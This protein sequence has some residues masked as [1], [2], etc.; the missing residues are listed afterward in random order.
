MY[1]LREGIFKLFIAFSILNAT[2]PAPPLIPEVQAIKNHEKITLMWDSKAENSIDPL[3]GYSDFAGYR[4]YRSTDG[5]I[6]WGTKIFNLGNHV[7]WKSYAQFD[8][9]AELDSLH[10]I[11]SNK[12]FEEGRED[13]ASDLCS[14]GLQC[15]RGQNVNGYDPI[16]NWVNLGK[17]TGLV[18]SF[19]DSTVLDGVEY[20]YAVTAY[21]MGMKSFNVDFINDATTDGTLED[22]EKTGDE[23]LDKSKCKSFTHCYWDENSCKY[24]DDDYC[25]G[26]SVLSEFCCDNSETIEVLCDGKESLNYL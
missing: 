20:T 26:C 2:D 19:I 21:D 6:T 24:T 25:S 3:T 23:A 8:L 14:G 15:T 4:I 18:R 10:C 22:C 17:N 7:G 16:A 11:Y 13:C 12:Y 9:I 5:G 1:N